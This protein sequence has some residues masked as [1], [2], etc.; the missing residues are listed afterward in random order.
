MTVSEAVDRRDE[1]VFMHGEDSEEARTAH[2]ALKTAILKRAGHVARTH[3]AKVPCLVC[4]YD[5]RARSG[6]AFCG[7]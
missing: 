5:R 4:G 7:A 1:A 6:C 3:R 2:L